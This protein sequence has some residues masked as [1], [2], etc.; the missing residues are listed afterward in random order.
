MKKFVLLFVSIITISVCKSQKLRVS[1]GA[2]F[3]KLD[4]NFSGQKF[5][6]D[7][8][9]SFTAGIGIEYAKLGVLSI[10]SN[11]EY[12]QK[13]G[14]DTILYT[15]ALGNEI[16][17]E[18]ITAKLNYIMLN[19]FAKVKPPMKGNTK[20]FLNAGLYAGYL[21]SANKTVG[22]ID[23]FHRLNFGTILGLG[24]GHYFSKFEIGIE[25]NYLLSLA[26]IYS[27]DGT[28]IKGNNGTVKLYFAVSL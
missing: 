26:K 27:K 16:R 23:N 13:A 28:E 1:A 4:W 2:S 20:P 5:F 18:T 11:L 24:I 22:S 8:A 21:A 6:P 12:L 19:T 10:S 9:S 17:K 3:G 25:G 15:D 14:K 7:N